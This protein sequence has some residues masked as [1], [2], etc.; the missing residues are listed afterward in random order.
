MKYFCRHIPVEGDVKVGDTFTSTK[1]NGDRYKASSIK[2]G[3]VYTSPL[4]FRFRIQDCTLNKLFLCSRDIQVGDEV[5]HGAIEGATQIV[6][7]VE[8]F[9]KP[10]EITGQF[11][12][13]IGEISPDAIWVKDGDEFEENDVEIF[14]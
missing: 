11:F 6:D 4:S 10:H 2:D 14:N 7:D 13:I 12:K 5:H 8:K 1:P 9:S 3:Y